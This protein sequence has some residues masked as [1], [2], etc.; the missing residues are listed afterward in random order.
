MISSVA[1][2]VSSQGLEVI[3]QLDAGQLD[4]RDV[5]LLDYSKVLCTYTHIH[6]RTKSI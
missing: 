2:P 3:Q 6:T 1:L 5:Y 4:L